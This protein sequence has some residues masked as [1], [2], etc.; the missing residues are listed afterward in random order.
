[1]YRTHRDIKAEILSLASQNDMISATDLFY[2]AELSWS[3][4]SRM[5]KTLV[6]QRMLCGK[7]F[8]KRKRYFLTVKGREWLS[9]YNRMKQLEGSEK[10]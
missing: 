10:T 9:L 5:R 6:R 4:A 8:G 1:M 7:P 2:K 3:Y